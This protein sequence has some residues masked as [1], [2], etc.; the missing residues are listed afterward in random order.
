MQFSE[1][2]LSVLKN[3]SQI[4][5]SIMFKP[6]QVL[7]TI[8]PQKTVMAAASIEEDFSME[9][10]VYDLGRFLSTLSLFDNPDI[11][12][13]ENQF[14][15]KDGKSSMKYTYTSENMIVCPPDRDI[16]VPDVV[17]TV[18]LAWKDIRK[19]RD[20]A[21][22][23][24]LPEVSFSSD[25][26]GVV[27]SAVDGKNSTAD[28]FSI[29]VAEDQEFTTFDMVI[30]TDYLKLI[31]NDYSISLS[32]KGMAHFVSDQVQYWIAIESR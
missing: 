22:V 1:N 9:A 19:V 25:G 8:S 32:S 20:A 4:N 31:E 24:S 17:A 16:V 23:L 29:S 13:Q 28:S 21:G 11:D 5:P 14:R 30:K 27:L 15:I 18:N 7:R 12:F 6:G 10:G 26:K 2:T 3:F